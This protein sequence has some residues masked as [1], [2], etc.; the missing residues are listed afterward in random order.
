M[1]SVT[2]AKGPVISGLAVGFILGSYL[3]SLIDHQ[4]FIGLWSFLIGLFGAGI[5]VWAGVKLSQRL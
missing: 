5:G 2:G 1:A 4:L 3:G